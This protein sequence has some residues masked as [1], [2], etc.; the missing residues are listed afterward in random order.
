MINRIKY[1]RQ[2]GSYMSGKRPVIAKGEKVVQVLVHADHMDEK[3]KNEFFGFQCLHY[4][5]S[6]ASGSLQIHI[7]NKKGMAGKVF[8]RTI[9]DQAKAGIDYEKVEE[10]VVFSN[11]ETTKF[12]EVKIN[13]DDDWEP[14]EDFYVQLYDA[15]TR[16]ELEGQDTKTRVTIIDDDKPGQICFQES[17]ATKAIASEGVAD[18]SIIR[19][20]GSDGVVKVDYETIQLGETDH[21]ATPG[22][23]Y[24]MEKGTLVF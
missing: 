23:D 6:E 2:V 20:N 5:V 4:S 15:D 3:L 17:R 12:I 14:D 24:V 9:D 16:Q 22:I 8:V 1:R 10:T 11:G 7:L 13:D 19:K 21:T 18:I